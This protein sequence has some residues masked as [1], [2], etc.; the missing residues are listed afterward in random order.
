MFW[1]KKADPSPVGVHLGQLQTMLS[2]TT[3]KAPLARPATMPRARA[4]ETEQ[5]AIS[6]QF[7]PLGHSA[8][9]SDFRLNCAALL[10]V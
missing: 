5:K 3:I 2:P 8:G 9:T 10:D 1:N 6:Y 7:R 4:A